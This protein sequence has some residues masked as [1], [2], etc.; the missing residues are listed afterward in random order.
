VALQFEL[1][2][3]L[4]VKVEGRPEVPGQ[5]PAVHGP[6]QRLLQRSIV[7]T[8]CP[9]TIYSLLNVQE[10]RRGVKIHNNLDSQ[11]CEQH[12]AAF[13]VS[14]VG[15]YEFAEGYASD[16]PQNAD[17]SKYACVIDE[18]VTATRDD[19]HNDI[20]PYAKRILDT[21]LHKYITFHEYAADQT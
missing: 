3:H 16:Q 18:E 12:P 5:A 13:R 19:K 4:T 14:E 21:N 15:M 17:R 8:Q 6:L 7:I 2:R 20:Q 9:V 11:G 1:R 10:K